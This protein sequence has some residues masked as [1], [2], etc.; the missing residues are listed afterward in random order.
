[1]R[2]DAPGEAGAPGG[3]AAEAVDGLAHGLER[4]RGVDLRPP[5]ADGARRVLL[6]R[7]LAVHGD[8]CSA[9]TAVQRGGRGFFAGVPCR[10]VLGFGRRARERTEWGVLGGV[11]GLFVGFNRKPLT[12]PR[13]SSRLVLAVGLG[14]THSCCLSVLQLQLAYARLSLNTTT[15]IQSDRSV[16]LC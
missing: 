4:R 2:E 6:P 10:W 15:N 12:G 14:L 13:A 8:S 1:M 9:G 11:C 7:L 3:A 5:A 16:V